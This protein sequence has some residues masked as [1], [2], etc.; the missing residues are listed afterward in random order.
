MQRIRHSLLDLLREALLQSLGDDAV[1]GGVGDL[2]GFLVGARVV[3]GVGDLLFDALG[4][5]WDKERMLVREECRWER[6]VV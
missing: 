5:L 2:A 1:A 6:G 4:D 3:E